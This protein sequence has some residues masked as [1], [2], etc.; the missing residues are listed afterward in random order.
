MQTDSRLS[1]LRAVAAL[2]V[3]AAAWVPC[4]ATLAEAPSTTLYF[5][6]HGETQRRLVSTGTGTFAEVCTPTRS[7]C[8]TPLNPLG[9]ARRDA[10]AA[11]FVEHGLA[12]QLTHLIATNKPRTVETLRALAFASRLGGDQNG[13][14]VLD[15][16]DDDLVPGDG[17]QQYPPQ[18]R[19]CDPGFEATTGSEPFIVA[20]IQ[21][22]PAGSQ[23]V[24]A[25]HSET[26][27]SIITVT[28]GIDTSDPVVFP[29]EQGSATR[30]RNFNDLW[31]VRMTGFG[32]GKLVRHVVFE[33]T[34]RSERE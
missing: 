2:A 11:W 7:C 8:E 12:Q 1:T 23:A 18:V 14:G 24:I 19:E 15:G 31:V 16:T 4:S 33:I 9:I 27:Y 10:L 30:V 32:T 34:L 5:I 29:K 28:T 6:R 13:D 20:A 22:L 21:A 25:N 3:A 26:L 17:I